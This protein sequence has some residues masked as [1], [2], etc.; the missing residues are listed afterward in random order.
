MPNFAYA[1]AVLGK[2]RDFKWIWNLKIWVYGLGL[3]SH[4]KDIIDAN[5]IETQ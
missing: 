1:S 2:K 5:I 4:M 3:W